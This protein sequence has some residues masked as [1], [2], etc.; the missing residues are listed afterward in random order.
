M[1]ADQKLAGLLSAQAEAGKIRPLDS[2]LLT[3]RCFM[4]M[5]LAYFVTQEILGGRKIMPLTSEAWVK[6]VVT[7]FLQGIQ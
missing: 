7:I 5:L 6:E 2:P 4:G 1:K 3:A